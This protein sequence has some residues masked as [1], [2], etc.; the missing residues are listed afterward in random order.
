MST[1]LTFCHSATSTSGFPSLAKTVGEDSLRAT[2]TSGS[3]TSASKSTPTNKPVNVGAIAGGTVGGVVAL[4]LIGA[5]IGFLMWRKKK[6]RVEPLRE[7]SQYGSSS[8]PGL[9][10]S[11]LSQGAS[12][13][14]GG[15][16]NR[17]Y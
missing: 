7:V 16:Y 12:Y 6:A 2:S 3:G 10:Y 4:A 9:S 5:V 14:Q 13:G 17:G 8:S 11:S 1:N 15:G